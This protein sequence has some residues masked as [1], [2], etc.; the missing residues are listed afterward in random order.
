LKK[1]I[2]FEEESLIEMFK[3]DYLEYKKKV[4]SGIPL[5]K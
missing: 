3:E 5:I 1:G 2:R 4:P